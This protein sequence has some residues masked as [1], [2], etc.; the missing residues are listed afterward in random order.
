MKWRRDLL[1]ALITLAVGVGVAC[2]LVWLWA[3]PPTPE[4]S[5]PPPEP[6]L[7]LFG[8]VIGLVVTLVG[9]VLLGRRLLTAQA[10]SATVP[11]GEDRKRLA[12]VSTRQ[13]SPRQA[14]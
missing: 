13:V 9:R 4:T 14:A 5:S 11:E 8:G 6:F 1:D 12:T 3:P 10:Y 7:F 2:A